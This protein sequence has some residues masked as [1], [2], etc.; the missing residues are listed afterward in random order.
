MG[1]PHRR[2]LGFRGLDALLERTAVRDAAK[3]AWNKLRIIHIAE[4]EEYLIFLSRIVVC[5]DVKGVS[6]LSGFRG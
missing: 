5:T 2:L 3:G 6:I 1:V 4:A